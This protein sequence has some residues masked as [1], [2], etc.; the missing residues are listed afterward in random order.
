MPKAICFR[1][2]SLPGLL[3]SSTHSFWL[4]L[5][6][7]YLSFQDMRVVLTKYALMFRPTRVQSNQK[8]LV[9]WDDDQLDVLI[10]Y[11]AIFTILF[12]VLNIHLHHNDYL[13]ILGWNLL[14]L[15]NKLRAVCLQNIRS[16]LFS[17]NSVHNFRRIVM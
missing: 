11:C 2:F 15:I 10:R 8:K 9:S 17:A 3:S 12:C 7:S 14:F 4:V 5:F 1:E 6:V 13:L 16:H